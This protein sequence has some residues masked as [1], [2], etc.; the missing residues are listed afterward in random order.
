MNPFTIRLALLLTT[1]F[2]PTASAADWPVTK[3]TLYPGYFQTLGNANLGDFPVS[4]NPKLTPE[5]VKEINGYF[6]EV[7]LELQ[8]HFPPPLYRD[9][10]ERSDGEMA[11]RIYYYEIPEGEDGHGSYATYQTNM[12]CDPDRSFI[13]LNPAKLTKGGRITAKGYGDMAHELFHAVQ[14]ATVAGGAGCRGGHE[15]AKW[16][17]EGQAEAIGHD[18]AYKLRGVRHDEPMTVHGLRRYGLPLAVGK[19]GS[20]KFVEEQTYQTSSFWRYLAERH[21]HS[22]LP[23]PD[24]GSGHGT[25][26]SYLGTLM[27]SAVTDA[28]WG[29]RNNEIRWLE[30]YLTTYFRASLKHLYPQFIAVFAD[31]PRYRFSG[32]NDAD[33]RARLWRDIAFST[34]QNGKQENCMQVQL[35]DREAEAQVTLKLDRIAT[36]CIDIEV[37]D[38]G[39]PLAWTVQVTADSEALLRQVRL[40]MPG[41]Q[42]IATSAAFAPVER[43]MAALYDFTLQP[44]RRQSL[45]VSNVHDEPT[46]TRDHEVTVIF[47]LDQSANE[48]PAPPPAAAASGPEPRPGPAGAAEARQR[49][50]ALALGQKAGSGTTTL[51]RQNAG[52]CR[53]CEAETQLDLTD[54][55]QLVPERV[56]A[57]MPG[58]YAAQMMDFSTSAAADPFTFM[59]DS[60]AGRVRI[61]LPGIEYGFTGK[62][63]GARIKVPGNPDLAALNPEP[64]YPNEPCVWTRPN[65]QVWIEEFTP[66]ILRGRYRA[67][68]VSTEIPRDSRRCPGKRVVKTLSGRFTVSAPW[69]ADP[70]QPIDMSWIAEDYGIDLARLT[71]EASESFE[72]PPDLQMPDSQIFT[73]EALDT[74]EVDPSSCDCS[75]DGFARAMQATQQL[76]SGAAQDPDAEVLVQCVGYCMADAIKANCDMGF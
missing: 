67:N 71:P 44:N 1:L 20:P 29:P 56:D 43:W 69:T 33:G 35:P 66:W 68:L 23:G 36:R 31:Y 51:S 49:N 24:Y 41:G 10:V 7:A 38:T 22:A 63:N 60:E 53:H 73:G 58:G 64:D 15:L 8:K 62:M 50:R 14:A 52:D 75:C 34:G 16:I 74:P 4:P 13:V 40:T 19:Q 55:P 76:M 5:L 37:G 70:D 61:T 17:I 30:N 21:H 42:Q 9:P 32:E 45:L 3:F 27:K 25:D 57:S 46:H 65:G 48:P 26:Y 72:T 12:I 39:A 47:S 2:V 28:G 18:L 59:N 54:S 6:E 11:L